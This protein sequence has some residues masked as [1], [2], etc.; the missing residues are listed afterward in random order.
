MKTPSSCSLSLLVVGTVMAAPVT[1]QIDPGHTYPSFE[2]DHLGGLSIL[3][4]KLTKT[5]GT[6]VLDK[7]GKTGT[8]DITVGCG[9]ARLR[10]NA[11]LNEKA[12]SEK[13][14]DV[15]KFPTIT[16][17]G[18]LAKFNGRFP[19]R[20]GRTA[21]AARRDEALEIDAQPVQVHAKPDDQT[22]RVRRGCL[23][24]VRSQCS[25]ELTT[26][27]TSASSRK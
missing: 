4:G 15:A 25:L 23:R 21:H 7:E 3:R 14:F 19:D 20:S 24:Y 8:V 16:Y 22:A 11:K 13:M 5:A 18:T 27:P 26:T 6:I 17:N 1:Y 2:A 12:K 9:V 10:P